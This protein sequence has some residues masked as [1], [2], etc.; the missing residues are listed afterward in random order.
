M[1]P[2]GKKIHCPDVLSNLPED[3]IDAILM[4]LPLQDAV[5]TS[6]LSKKWRYYWCRLQALT[7]D[8]SL[9]KTEKDKEYP[10]TKLVNVMYHI[11]TFVTRPITKFSL[12]PPYLESCPKMDN[13]LHF[14][15]KNGINHLVLNLA[16]TNLYKLPVSFFTCLQMKHLTLQYCLILPPP[17]FTGF[18]RLIRLEL[19]DVTISSKSLESLIGHAKFLEHLALVNA[20]VLDISDHIQI[21]TPKLRFLDYTSSIRSISLVNVPLLEE[22]C[23]TSDEPSENSRIC[24]I[25]TFFES[26]NSL[27]H[28]HLSYDNIKV[29]AEGGVPKRLPFDL[30]CVKRLC[31]CIGFDEVDVVLCGLCLIRSFPYLQYLEIEM[32][33]C[34]V[35]VPALECLEVEGCSDLTFPHL[36][37]V[38]LFVI[39]SIPEMQFIKL[40]LSKS[41]VL[42]RMLIESWIE[43]I[44]RI[45]KRLDEL[46]NCWRAS[47][48]AEV[49][50][51][52]N[53]VPYNNPV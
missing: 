3:V 31:L 30:T 4:F 6:I 28:L 46:A 1:P 32:K 15:S 50:F 42:K 43:D 27:E 21:N 44:R 7:L 5:Q 26:C 20:P 24:D 34:C 14:L 29:L 51:D 16:S 48:E 2:T 36:I 37:E 9:W 41:Q 38:K 19:Y 12:D 47:P 35:D 10:T 39:G 23:L 13:L 52:L 8:R 17:D 40:L 53:K 18:D 33:Y 45:D 25:A 49:V 11:L 22:L